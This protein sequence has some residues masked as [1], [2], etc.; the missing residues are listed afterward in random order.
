MLPKKEILK[1]I[2]LNRKK[3]LEKSIHKVIKRNEKIFEEL[4]KH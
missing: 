3:Q 2:T 4:A 1:F